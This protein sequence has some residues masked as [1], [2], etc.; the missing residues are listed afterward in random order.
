[1]LER[2]S[3]TGIGPAVPFDLEL[4]SRL[5]LITA[6]NALSTTV[7]L[8]LVWWTL[9]RS[10]PTRLHL[11]ESALVL[12]SEV[13]APGRT[14][15]R[16]P[17]AVGEAAIDYRFRTE[18]GDRRDGRCRYRP[19]PPQPLEAW[20]QEDGQLW[21]ENTRTVI[22][23]R[24]DG[25]VSLYYPAGLDQISVYE[26]HTASGRPF[27]LHMTEDELWH[28]ARRPEHKVGCNG[29]FFDWRRWL[30]EEPETLARLQSLVSALVP[31]SEPITLLPHPL[32]LREADYLNVP[33]LQLAQG[34]APVYAAAAGVR[35]LLALAYL[36]LWP[37]V[38]DGHQRRKTILEDERI[39][40]L[41]DEADSH[42]S[43]G[44]G[45]ALAAA[46]PALAEALG[47][48]EKLQF[49]VTARTD[50]F[51]EGLAGRTDPDTDRRYRYEGIEGGAARLRA[52]GW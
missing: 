21:R 30:A 11:P 25:G 18:T 36:L 7:P 43:V 35:R 47:L 49:L 44:W 10:W 19:R 6:D 22:Y 37:Q 48:A 4:G 14:G 46:L 33:V 32:A 1:M 45:Q 42:L 24:A 3:L 2:F 16:R 31:A 40:V 39:M 12:V 13:E 41:I 17:D 15:G 52:V 9:T 38:G 50:A 26:F 29:L 8:D 28:G 23:A 27:A 51:A 5:T 34:R 20:W